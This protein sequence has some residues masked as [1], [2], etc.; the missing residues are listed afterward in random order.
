MRSVTEISQIT[1]SPPFTPR[2]CQVVYLPITKVRLLRNGEHV[3]RSG[4][5]KAALDYNNDSRVVL[6]S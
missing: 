1:T 2:R 5:V 4:H 6:F 3:G